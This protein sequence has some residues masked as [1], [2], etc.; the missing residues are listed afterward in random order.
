MKNILRFSLALIG[1]ILI[2][3]CSNSLEE[4]VKF[5]VDADKEISDGVITIQKGEPITFLFNGDPDFITLYSGESGNVYAKRDQT[6]SSVDDINSVLK[7]DVFTQY[8]FPEGTLKVKISKNFEGLTKDA[9]VDSKAIEA[10]EWVDVSESCN[11]PTKSTGK[12]SVELPLD[13]FLSSDLSI[14]FHYNP[15]DD[16]FKGPQS[17]WEITDLRIENTDK[18]SGD[19]SQFIVND[20]GFTPFDFNQLAVENGDP[21]KTAKANNEGGVWNLMKLIEVPAML[22]IHSTPPAIKV[23]NNNWLISYPLKI[24][25]RTP[26]KGV[27]IK[28][29]HN[30]VNEYTHEYTRAGEYDVTFI[31]TNGNYKHTSRVIREFKIIV[32]E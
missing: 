2:S 31:G 9:T 15:W 23:L 29:I 32:T 20:M 21:Y 8:G 7:F 25:T 22:R 26:D 4:S 1:S 28:T 6:E 18:K 5:S 30:Y 16:S 17:I 24:N 10:A 12:A 3:G 11:L 14:A 27:S 13:E 19:V